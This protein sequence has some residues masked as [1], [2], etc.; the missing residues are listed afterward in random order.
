MNL[1]TELLEKYG[2]KYRRLIVSA[3]Q[4]L[5]NNESSWGLVTCIDRR[6]YIAHL[7][8]RA[9]PTGMEP[10]IFIPTP[11]LKRP[12]SL[13]EFNDHHKIGI[14]FDDTLV[15]H[16]HSHRIQKYILDNQHKEFYIITYRSHGWQRKIHIDL[17]EY[18]KQT[19]I[20]LLVEHFIGVHNI[21]DGSYENH[22]AMKGDPSYFSW[23][24][25]KC[26]ELGCTILIDDFADAFHEHFTERGIVIV[27]PDDLDL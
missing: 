21:D 23:K 1:A 17:N 12:F 10:M 4:F 7:V 6:E 14:D 25:R 3:L 9:R 8:E 20:P 24:A 16:K 11:R 15:G 27:S 26:V 5:D 13:E 2:G 22:V 18:T 19:G